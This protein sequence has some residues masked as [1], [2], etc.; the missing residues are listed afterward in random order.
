MCSDAVSVHGHSG[1]AVHA[2]RGGDLWNSRGRDKQL[3]DRHSPAH[4]CPPTYALDCSR[5][6]HTTKVRL[7]LDTLD[8][9]VWQIFYKQ[10]L[11]V[12]SSIIITIKT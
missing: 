9:S 11:T 4:P 7:V 12:R 6:V 10:Q 3:I 5:V 1:A 2:W 8:V